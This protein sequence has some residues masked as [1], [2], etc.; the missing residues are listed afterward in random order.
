MISKRTK[1]VTVVVVVVVIII[2]AG[3]ALSVQGPEPT[4][5]Q[6]MM[7]TANDFNR[8]TYAQLDA[9]YPSASIDWTYNQ[10]LTAWGTFENDTLMVH[11]QLFVFNSVQ[12]AHYYYCSPFG[13]SYQL[14]RGQNITGTAAVGDA[15]TIANSSDSFGRY[16][17]VFLRND[18]VAYVGVQ[19][20]QQ[21]NYPWT[22]PSWQYDATITIAH[23]QALKIDQHTAE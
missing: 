5:P 21:S 8:G 14:G 9:E 22:I 23:L 18:V 4:A 13:S 16:V 10:S 19:Y 2:L 7:L 15:V 3:L 20:L 1:I 6:K 17:V 12:D 11:V